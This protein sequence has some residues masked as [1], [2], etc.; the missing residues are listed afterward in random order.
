[1]VQQNPM[2]R[3]PRGSDGMDEQIRPTAQRGERR[4][5]AGDSTPCRPRSRPGLGGERQIRKAT[6][7]T[8]RNLVPCVV[9]DRGGP[10]ASSS[11][12]TPSSTPKRHRRVRIQRRWRC[13]ETFRGAYRDFEVLPASAFAKLAD[14]VSFSEA[15]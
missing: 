14:R 5:A 10:A 15:G 8:P 1:M 9:P 13:D 12:D 6:A 2:R 3:F 4:S 7:V 11:V